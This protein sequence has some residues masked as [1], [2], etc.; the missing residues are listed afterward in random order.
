VITAGIGLGAAGAAGLSLEARQS[1][2]KAIDVSLTNKTSE[3]FSAYLGGLCKGAGKPAFKFV[4]RR[5]GQPDEPLYL[6]YN[7]GHESVICGNPDL[8]IVFLPL[9]SRYEFTFF[10]TE[11]RFLHNTKRSLADVSGPYYVDMS[12]DVS[13]ERDAHS[14]AGHGQVPDKLL[15]QGR[16]SATLFHP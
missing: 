12:Y 8:W 1:S 6:D 3:N 11:L 9:R 10:F 13:L 7:V 14:F 4:L 5:D 15:W 16:I 2:Q